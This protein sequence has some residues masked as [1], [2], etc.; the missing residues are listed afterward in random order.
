MKIQDY[1]F[2]ASNFAFFITSLKFFEKK[3]Y[4]HAMIALIVGYIA[5]TSHLKQCK[6]QEGCYFNTIQQE[7]TTDFFASII[8]VIMLMILRH[9]R[10]NQIV[11]Y[12]LLTTFLT[13]MYLPSNQLSWIPHSIWHLV[14]PLGYFF[15][16]V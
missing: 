5:L 6:T 1:F 13:V 12:G 7:F 4:I 14:L 15:I 11:L 8:A 16:L 9:N 10:W 3:R 2:L